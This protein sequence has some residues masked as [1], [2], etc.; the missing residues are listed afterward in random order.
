MDFLTRKIFVS[1]WN[2]LVQIKFSV[3]CY[4]SDFEFGYCLSDALKLSPF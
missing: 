2:A 4:I 1:V 3:Y